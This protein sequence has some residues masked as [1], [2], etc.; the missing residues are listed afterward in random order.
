MPHKMPMCRLSWKALAAKPTTVG[1]PLQPKSP[2]R[3]SSAKRAVPPFGIAAL[4]ILK[5]PGHIIPTESPQK[6]QPS[7]LNTGLGESDMVR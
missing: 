7:R 1:P 6:P 5:L 4:A 3:A 2:A